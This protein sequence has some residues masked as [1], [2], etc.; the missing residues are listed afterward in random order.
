MPKAGKPRR[1]EK[2]LIHMTTETKSRKK[3][4]SRI[5]RMELESVTQNIQR[6]VQD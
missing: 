6:K 1:D 2:I 5:T 4:N 3:S